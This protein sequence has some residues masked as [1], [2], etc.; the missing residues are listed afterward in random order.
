MAKTRSR[1]RPALS[2]QERLKFSADQARSAAHDMPPGAERDL[3]VQKALES[4]AA[5]NIDRCL[6]SS[7]LQRPNRRVRYP[8]TGKS[9]TSRSVPV[10]C[11]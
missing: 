5:A 9:V 11:R 7:G 8:E 4:E 1:K 6:S 3:L 2:F 10:P